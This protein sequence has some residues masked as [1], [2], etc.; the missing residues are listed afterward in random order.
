MNLHV[1]IVRVGR[2]NRIQVKHP[3]YSVVVVQLVATTLNLTVTGRVALGLHCQTPD[4]EIQIRIRVTPRR[5]SRRQSSSQPPG[6]VNCNF[7]KCFITS[8]FIQV[9]FFFSSFIVQ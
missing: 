8:N 1:Q 6:L 5:Q 7:L 3:A 2:I 4:L 9:S